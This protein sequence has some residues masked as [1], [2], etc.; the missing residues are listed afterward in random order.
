MAKFLFILW[1]GLHLHLLHGCTLLDTLLNRQNYLMLYI[2]DDVPYKPRSNGMWTTVLWRNLV[3]EPP[4]IPSQNLI[5]SSFTFRWSTIRIGLFTHMMLWFCVQG[6]LGSPIL[7]PYQTWANLRV[8]SC[9]ARNIRMLP[10]L[11]SVRR[12]WWSVTAPL[13]WI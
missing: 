8:I 7:H 10:V 11:V 12:Y 5:R 9:T 4:E 3:L 2:Q 13:D 1:R 6:Y